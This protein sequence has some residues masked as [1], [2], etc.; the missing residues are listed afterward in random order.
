M[1]AFLSL[2]SSLAKRPHPSR[3]VSECANELMGACELNCLGKTLMF[4]FAFLFCLRKRELTFV[5]FSC[6]L[7]LAE[8]KQA[9]DEF[10]GLGLQRL[11]SLIRAEH[12]S[13]SV[14]TKQYVLS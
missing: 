13:K 5:F 11:G 2:M 4:R 9:K 8:P 12:I 14:L 6:E 10:N 3:L 7:S 1:C